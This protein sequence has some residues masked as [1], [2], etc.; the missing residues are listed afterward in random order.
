MNTFFDS[1][2]PVW[3]WLLKCSAQ[4]AV[5][6]LLVLL[7]QWL[8]RKRLA[9]RWRYALWFLV[10]ARL[11]LPVSPQSAWSIFNLA[12]GREQPVAAM[13]QPPSPPDI[14]PDHFAANWQPPTPSESA[15]TVAVGEN[16]KPLLKSPPS[17]P[18]SKPFSERLRDLLTVGWL[19]LSRCIAAALVR[20]RFAAGR[21]RGL[22]KLAIDTSP[23]P[24]FAGGRSGG[25]GAA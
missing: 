24:P 11:A 4:A 16:S 22:G 2:H 25:V 20:W 1:S 23:A 21:A 8:F 6:V 7:V 12:P 14:E 15:R 18:P 13:A 10:V 17:K 3:H 19:K 5:L 9:P